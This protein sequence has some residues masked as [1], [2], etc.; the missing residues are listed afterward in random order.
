MDHNAL[1]NIQPLG[2]KRNLIFKYLA[3]GSAHAKDKIKPQAH[4]IA[5]FSDILHGEIDSHKSL[6]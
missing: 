1:A 6:K 4:G 3:P 2:K 5:L